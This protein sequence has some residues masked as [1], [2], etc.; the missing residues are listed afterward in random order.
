MVDRETRDN[1]MSHPFDAQE[2]KET[3]GALFEINVSLA[4]YTSSRIGGLAD[5][6][7]VAES[8]ED[9]VRIATYLWEKEIPFVILGGGSN[10]LV[11]DSGVRGIVLLNRARQI[12]FQEENDP[13]LVWAASGTNFGLL[14]RQAATFGF[15][16]LE[17]A[18]GIPGTLG[19]AIVGNAG[20]HGGDIA[21]NLLMAEILHL[22][23]A[24]RRSANGN[25][26]S[27]EIRRE[28]WPTE[29]FGFGYRS[30]KL[31]PAG[32]PLGDDVSQ[33]GRIEIR[34]PEFI[35]LAGLLQ[36][37][38]SSKELVEGRLEELI[39]R[40]RLTQP[41]GASMGSMFKNPKGDF[42]G[43]LIE[44][45]GLKGTRVGDAAISTLHANFFINYGNASAADVWDL[46]NIARSVVAKKFG[47]ELELEIELIGSWGVDYRS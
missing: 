39:A 46:I 9:L 2:M 14:A 19:G 6:L 7:L 3:F 15:S 44:Q 38:R 22:E 10:V 24:D 30:S 33:K 16:G 37:V 32:Q 28:N 25:P 26:P 18:S 1:L 43:R 35:V 23:Y 13:P 29:Q 17:W 36:L 41:P 27:R 34:Q 42:A 31:K 20:A 21:G 5:G 8:I 40:R 47:V 45:A 12:R 4:R 11:S